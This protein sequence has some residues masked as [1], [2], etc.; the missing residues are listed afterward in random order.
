[1]YLK[2]LLAG[3]IFIFGVHVAEAATWTPV[4]GNLLDDGT[5][6]NLSTHK[7]IRWNNAIK[8]PEVCYSGT[9]YPFLSGGSPIGGGY[10]YDIASSICRWPNPSTGDCTCPS[11]YQTA[12]ISYATSG[13]NAVRGSICY[14]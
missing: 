9:W 6:C 7:S 14:K 2:T 10:S 13:G 1:M 4:T 12:H 11:G 5:A 3:W 8:Q